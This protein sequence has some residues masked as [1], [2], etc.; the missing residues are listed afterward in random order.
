[1]ERERG[2]R[3][4][5]AIP[6]SEVPPAPVKPKFAPPI[7]WWKLDDE[8]RAEVLEVLVEWVP[9]L[10]RRYMLREQIVPSCWFKHQELIQELLALFQYRNQQQFLEVAPPSAPLDFHYQLQ[11]SIGRLRSWV[12]EA[13]CK[14][15]MHEGRAL[16]KWADPATPAGAMWPEEATY[17]SI[18]LWSE[19]DQ[20]D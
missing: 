12:G 14:P 8:E 15:G 13:G 9:E 5:R 7:D 18:E 3:P 11:L 10:V 19:G 6:P 4:E 17:E 20:D 1:M 16:P 2:A